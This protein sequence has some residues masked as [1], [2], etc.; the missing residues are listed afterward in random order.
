[1]NEKNAALVESALKE[2]YFNHF[3]LIQVP[4]QPTKREFGYQKINGTMIR[5]LS[6]KD[7]KELHLLLMK[8]IPSDIYCSN[9][10]YSFPSMPMSEKDWQGADLIFDIDA[11]DL[12]LSC[13][14]D[15]TVSKCSSCQQIKDEQQSQCSR[16]NSTK[17]EVWSVACKNCINESKKEVKKLIEILISDLGVQNEEIDTHFSGNEG[18]H[19]RVVNTDYQI[20]GSQ[21]RA[22]LADYVMFNGI[23]P[24]TF[25]I[26]KQTNSK[27]L[28]PNIDD[29]GWRGRVAKTLFESKTRTSKITKQI[30]SGGYSAFQLKLEEMHQVIGVKIDP[31]VTM[32]I[33]RIFRLEGS[34]NSKSGLSK[35]PCKDLDKFDPFSDACLLSEEKVEIEATMPLPIKLKNKKYGPYNNERV[36]V[37]KYAAV[38]MICK[39]LANAV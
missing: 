17:F 39:G 18:F 26:R 13:R 32:D 14:K 22:D 7:N 11:K 1:M 38:Y 37:P 15:H 5:H 29:Q 12:A 4:P 3:D 33:H 9:A 24:E 25:G 30:I 23:M 21:E 31:K 35:V 2:Y 36:S 16:C 20:L 6:I 8:E 34:I 19:V 28:L 27:S 10:Y